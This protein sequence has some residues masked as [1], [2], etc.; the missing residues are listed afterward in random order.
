MQ[1]A[2]TPSPAHVLRPPALGPHSKSWAPQ[3]G[4][5]SFGDLPSHH[6]FAGLLAAYRSSGGT[7]RGDDVARLLED[8]RLGDFVSLARLIASGEVFSFEWRGTHWIPMFQFE[9]RDF[10]VKPAPRLVL[11]ELGPGFDGWERAAWFAE[12]NTW[13][14]DRRPVDMIETELADVLAAART[15]RFIAVG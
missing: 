9:L 4:A 6:G 14:N 8:Y 7:A 13:L 1:H 5:A 11:A 15:D 3:A 10:S 12:R 2:L